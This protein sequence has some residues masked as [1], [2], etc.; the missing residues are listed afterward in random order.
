M[1]RDG[2]TFV[3]GAGASFEFGFPVGT[4]LA[5]RIKKSSFLK[6]DDFH[7]PPAYGDSFFYETITRIWRTAEDRKPVCEALN[8][9][10]TGI[11]TAVSIDAFI[12]R[13]AQHDLIP[14]LGKMLIA[15]EIARAERSCTLHENNA[16]SLDLAT[17]LH[18]DHTWIGQFIRILF[19]GV[20]Q[21]HDVGKGVSIICFNYD[22]CFEYYLR[23]AL[24]A[25]YRIHIDEAHEIVLG[26]NIIHPYG[27][28]GELTVMRS[29]VGD[30]KLAFGPEL[31]AYVKLDEIAKNIRTYTEGFEDSNLIERIHNAIAECNVLTFLGFGFNNQ[32]LDLLRVA[33]RK[34]LQPRNIYSTGVRISRDVEDTM[35]R[36][37]RHIF[38]DRAPGPVTQMWNSRI[39]V[40]YDL[41]CSRLFDTHNMN[42]TSFTRRHVVSSDG[43]PSLQMVSKTNPSEDD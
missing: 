23:N 2:S 38:I 3:I 7:Q 4:G 37:I 27:T 39:Q 19:D 11:H 43:Y 21:A 25:A 26:M 28:L 41:T 29:G 13:N 5:D 12:H 8:A 17:D 30:K 14:F 10:H 6:I 15:L 42:L 31:D 24:V 35:K 22:R 1:F 33:Y 34:D 18:P 36:R 20:S 32:N 16:T 40:G 9:I